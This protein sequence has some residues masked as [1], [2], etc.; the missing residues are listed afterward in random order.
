[1]PI[2]S[3]KPPETS[4][5]APTGLFELQRITTAVSAAVEEIGLSLIGNKTNQYEVV[6]FFLVAKQQ[7]DRK[8]S[9][10][11]VAEDK[12][13]F[14]ATLALTV[15]NK[16]LNVQKQIDVKL[17][18]EEKPAASPS[19]LSTYTYRCEVDPKEMSLADQYYFI[20][21][22]ALKIMQSSDV[23]TVARIVKVDTL[24]PAEKEILVEAHFKAGYTEVYY[25]GEQQTRRSASVTYEAA[26]AAPS[27]PRA[28]ISPIVAAAPPNSPVTSTPPVPVVETSR[29]ER[30]EAAV[31]SDEAEPSRGPT[32]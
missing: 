25:G 17:V 16:T 28:S 4:V 18:G 29:S 31:N 11:T 14:T 19:E 5:L 22:Q 32:P 12:K 30:S 9:G 3:R 7:G 26:P 15:E 8:T 21:L 24:S 20:A 10:I 6:N 1:M 2:E 13:S 27:S 23:T